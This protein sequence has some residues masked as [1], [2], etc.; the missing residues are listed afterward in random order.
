MRSPGYPY[1]FKKVLVG[2]VPA[3]PHDNTPALLPIETP[4]STSG[5]TLKMAYNQTH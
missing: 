5:A 4:S 1:N 3:S 2:T